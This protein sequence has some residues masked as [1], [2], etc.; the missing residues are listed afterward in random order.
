M[1]KHSFT[2]FHNN[3]GNGNDCSVSVV[4][5]SLP[6]EWLDFKLKY[7]N[8]NL[9]SLFWSTAIEVN[10][11]YFEIEQSEDGKTFKYLAK[12]QGA[13]TS[14]LI[15]DYSYKHKLNIQGL[16]YYC[17]KQVDFDGNYSYSDFK[18]I[19]IKD[20]GRISMYPNPVFETLNINSIND[21]VIFHIVDRHGTKILSTKSNKINLETLSD[22]MYILVVQIIN[23]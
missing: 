13:G 5:I 19:N 21:D 11:D 12:V 14:N 3:S 10:N 4:G 16:S 22:G 2:A 15:N 1:F 9:I 23:T 8:D 6:V 18:H 20:L 17:I 7:E